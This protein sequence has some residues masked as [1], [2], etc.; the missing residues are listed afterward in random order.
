MMR[1]LGI[2]PMGLISLAATMLPRPRDEAERVE[3]KPK[4]E[5]FASRQQ[6]RQ[7]ERRA[8]KGKRT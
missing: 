4:P 6:R 2:F 5:R 8:G 3:A 1:R 7:A